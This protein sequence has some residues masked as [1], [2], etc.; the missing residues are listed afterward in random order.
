MYKDTII[1]PKCGKE[2]SFVKLVDAIDESGEFYRCQHC[3]WP[4]HYALSYIN[5]N[6]CRCNPA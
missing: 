4:F 2:T 1:C 3:K 5:T 6:T